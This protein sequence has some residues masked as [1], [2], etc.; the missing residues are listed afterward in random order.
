MQA[1]LDKKEGSTILYLHGSVQT[2]LE[3]TVSAFHLKKIDLNQFHFAL[4][5]GT[6]SDKEKI[7]ETAVLHMQPYVSW[8]EKKKVHAETQKILKSPFLMGINERMAQGYLIHEKD[9]SKLTLQQLYEQ[10]A[11]QHEKGF[12]IVGHMRFSSLHSTYVQLPPIFKEN[13]NEKSKK[14]WAEPLKE[15]N[16]S[17]CFFGV[18]IPQTAQEVFSLDLLKKAFYENPKE[19]KKSPLSS[20]THGAVLSEYTLPQVQD[21]ASFYPTFDKL[22]IKGVRHLLTSSVIEEGYLGIY[23]IDKIEPI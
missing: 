4:G 5:A 8:V 13:I 6:F 22:E 2:V 1:H 19:S 14:Y 3:G 11:E 20:H 9:T 23:P 7:G 16:M 17:C 18:V 15:K 12:A 10:L 21:F